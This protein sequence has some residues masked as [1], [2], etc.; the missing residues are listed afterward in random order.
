MAH[1]RRSERRQT[2]ARAGGSGRASD[3]LSARRLALKETVEEAPGEPGEPA[4]FGTESSRSAQSFAELDS[5]TVPDDRTGRLIEASLSIESNG[6]ARVKVNGTIYGG[7]TGSVDVALPF[8]GAFLLPGSTVSVD[9][10]STDGASTTTKAAVTV[11]E[12]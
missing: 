4:G 3:S 10:Q 6:E 1:Q 2:M 8:D 5:Y 11:Q 7:F 12:V 9:H